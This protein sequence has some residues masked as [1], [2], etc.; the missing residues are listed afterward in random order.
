MTQ[1]V[2]LYTLLKTFS[3]KNYTAVIGTEMFIKF[4]EKNAQREDAAVLNIDDWKTD[5]RGKIQRGLSELLQQKKILLEESAENQKII[6]L[7]FYSDIISKYFAL[8]DPKSSVPFPNDELLRTTIPESIVKT[9]SVESG[10]VNFLSQ[11]FENPSQIIRIIFP[12]Q[13]GIGYTLEAQ[14]PT[15]V[16]EFALSIV[17][18]T[19]RSRVDLEFYSQKMMS[20][21]KGQEIRIRNFISLLTS[22]P[23]E[24][25]LHIEESSEF[26]YALWL[27]LCPLI[28]KHIEE[29]IMISRERSREQIALGQAAAVILSINNH[30]QILAINKRNTA[31]ALETV[32]EKMLEAPFLFTVPDI[33]EFKNPVGGYLNQRYTL[34]ELDV[35][36]KEKTT[37][38]GENKLPCVLKYKSKEGIEWYIRKDQVWT[39]AI[40]ALTDAM[41]QI[42]SELTQRWIRTL[43]EFRRESAMDKDSDFDELLLK[44]CNLFAPQMLTVIQDKKT[45][46]LQAELLEATGTLPKNEKF[47][48]VSK[49]IAPRILLGLRKE[50]IIHNCKLALPFWYSIGFIVKFIGVFRN[51]GKQRDAKGA[52][53]DKAD[54]KSS[55]A[56]S[57]H[58]SARELAGLLVPEGSKIDDYLDSLRDRWNQ[59]L[60]RYAQK[61][62]TDDVHAIVKAHLNQIL[63]FQKPHSFDNQMLE[64][65]AERVIK[66]NAALDKI[67]NKN[68]L[69][70][71][72][73]VYIT[74][75]LLNI[76][77]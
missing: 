8:Q 72:I 48:D 29:S 26:T 35:F 64:E 67:N 73:K 55:G 66:M 68:A 44:L 27:F 52:L 43:R 24:C 40:K 30:Y 58:D 11:P 37:D 6:L 57:L 33:L 62:L 59:M 39:F 1:K 18:R 32:Y 13:Y 31:L 56:K 50:D 38:A 21:F 36:L 19:L 60:D 75:L 76:K 41:P 47:F 28:K 16:L 34:A 10:L 25:I 65:N 77:K 15:Q 61:K 42:K 54:G 63:K 74:K 70:L 12:D 22:R 2:E 23:A 51:K 7:S 20:H 46:V 53:A 69:C 17:E 49:P 45:A 4:M 5:T 9:V 71:Y 14:Y 3:Q